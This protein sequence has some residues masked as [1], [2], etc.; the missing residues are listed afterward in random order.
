MLYGITDHQHSSMNIM[1]N[2]FQSD[3]DVIN[4]HLNDIYNFDIIEKNYTFYLPNLFRNLGHVDKDQVI[5]TDYKYDP[6]VC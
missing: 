5:H 3:C 1:L 6:N 4:H 2:I